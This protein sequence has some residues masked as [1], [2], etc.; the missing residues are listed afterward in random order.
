MPNV[1]N[2]IAIKKLEAVVTKVKT[3]DPSC[4]VCAGGEAPNGAA[5]AIRVGGS[6][7][8]SAADTGSN[9]CNGVTPSAATYSAGTVATNGNPAITGPSGGSAM[10]TGV[11]Q[12]NFT[13]FLFSDA[14]MVMLKALAKANGTYYQGNQAWT[15]PPPNGIIFVDTPSGNLLSS[16][17]MATGARAGTGGSWSRAPLRSAV[18]RR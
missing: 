10:M 4:A 8:I 11:P 7:S 15:S 12:S 14:D 13:D 2:P 16:I 6:A 1:A 9:Y 3:L 18:T 17:S 5:T